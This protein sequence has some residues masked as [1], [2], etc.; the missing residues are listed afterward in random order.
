MVGNAKTQRSCCFQSHFPYK[1][2]CQSSCRGPA[3]GGRQF[4]AWT[5]I[6]CP[7][8]TNTWW[9]HAGPT[10]WSV[11][12]CPWMREWWAEDERFSASASLSPTFRKEA[13][14]PTA[15]VLPHSDAYLWAR[16]LCILLQH[17]DKCWCRIASAG[18]RLVRTGGEVNAIFWPKLQFIY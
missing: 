6:P 16:K 18:L 2:K 13:A 9:I 11:T 3:V 14:I 17:K 4:C 5:V 10:R 8:C 15:T 12:Q 1:N 7:T